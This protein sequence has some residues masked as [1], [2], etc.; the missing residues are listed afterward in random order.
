ME[1]IDSNRLAD[2]CPLLTEKAEVADTPERFVFTGSGSEYFRIWI[3]NLLLSIVTLGIYSAW[4]KVRKTRYFYDNTTLAGASFDYHGNPWSILRGRIIAALFFGAYNVAFSMSSMAGFVM[5]AMLG[6]IMPW[7]IWKSLQFKLYNSSYR[8]IRFGFAGSMGKI[9]YVYFLLPVVTLLTAYLLAPFAHQRMKKFQHE[10][11]RYGDTHFSFHAS[12]GKFYGAYLLALAIAV[13]GIFMIGIAFGGTFVG[14]KESGLKHAGTAAIG[15]FLLFVAALCIWIFSLF[16]VF[17]TLLQNLIW[18][19]TRLGDHRFA[20]RMT[21]GKMVFIT[22][23]NMLGVI[24]TLG[25]FIPFA[26]I[27]MMKYRIESMSL[28]P[29]DTLDS[30]ITDTQ[31]KASATGEGMVDVFDLDLSL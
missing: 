26:Q 11:S 20:C 29:A 6:M 3:V 8:G 21:L 22:V 25:L 10:Q 17:L 24:A 27:R 9:Y 5:L 19:N 7:T 2:T 14:L 28:M 12:A 13:I 15:S 23:T 31:A 1:I 16:P 30:F 4:A 18:N